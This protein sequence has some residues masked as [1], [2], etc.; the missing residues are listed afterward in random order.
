M[1]V[2]DPEIKLSCPPVHRRALNPKH[3]NGKNGCLSHLRR[4]TSSA[5]SAFV[6][7]SIG[8]IYSIRTFF[9]YRPN[10]TDPTKAI[11]SNSTTLTRRGHV[12]MDGD[13][14]GATAAYSRRSCG[15]T[16]TCY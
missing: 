1:V 7:M 13:T 15:Q 12:A 5:V 9:S 2:V 6:M 16:Q 8:A 4:L 11:C 14:C 10:E 3:C